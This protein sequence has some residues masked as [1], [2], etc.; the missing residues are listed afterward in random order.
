MIYELLLA[1]M[2]VESGGK[3]NA[4]GDKGKAVGAYQIH[5]IMV[6]EVNRIAKKEMFSLNDRLCPQCSAMMCTLFLT[7]QRVRYIEEYHEEP[8]VIRLGSAWNTG[9]ILKE[10]PEEYSKR[11]ERAL[12]NVRNAEMN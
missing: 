1:I 7:Y 8:D 5:P 12:A 6:K 10:P 3:P 11:L 2:M 9:N 4:V